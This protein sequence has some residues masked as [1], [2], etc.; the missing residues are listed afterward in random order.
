MERMDSAKQKTI[1]RKR[2]EAN[3]W[4]GAIE[5]QNEILKE[6]V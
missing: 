3:Q 2:G 6:K 4:R 5:Q 1:N